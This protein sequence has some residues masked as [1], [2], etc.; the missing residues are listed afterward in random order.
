MHDQ[1][2]ITITL[3]V[4]I[5]RASISIYRTKRTSKI[6]ASFGCCRSPFEALGDCPEVRTL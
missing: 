6:D 2:P 4:L 5:W 3:Q 1:L